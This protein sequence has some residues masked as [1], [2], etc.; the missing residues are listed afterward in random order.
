[1][2]MELLA[3]KAVTV[4]D[5]TREARLRTVWESSMSDFS[6]QK[7]LRIIRNEP[8]SGPSQ[9]EY[10]DA[11]RLD[12]ALEETP[13]EDRFLS[14]IPTFPPDSS[15][16]KGSFPSF[17]AFRRRQSSEDAKQPV[18]GDLRKLVLRENI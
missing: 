18:I 5:D 1:M 9:H 8:R 12:K 17:S 11:W 13:F 7:S 2:L 10:T 16:R 14:L 3:L 4:D 15:K 6:K